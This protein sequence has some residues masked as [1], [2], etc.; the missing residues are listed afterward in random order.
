MATSVVTPAV[1]AVPAKSSSQ[2]LTDMSPEQK[3]HWQKTG[4]IVDTVPAKVETPKVS[5]EGAESSTAAKPVV[6]GA[7]KPETPAA[8]APA[9]SEPKGKPD[10]QSRI[11]Q[12]LADNKALQAKLDDL[13]KKPAAAAAPT[14]KKEELTKPQ[15]AD[16]D[17]K[18]G[19]A[20]YATDD[21]FET[22][23]EEYL[24]KKI[25][26]DIERDNAVAAKKAHDDEQQRLVT[27]KWNNSMKVGKEKH[28]DLDEVFET[29][30]KGAIQHPEIKGIK[31]G[32]ILD[33]WVVDSDLGI[34]IL[35][36]C[37]TTAGEVA[38]IQAMKPFEATRYLTKLEDK[39]SGTPSPKPPETPPAKRNISS[40]PAP[41]ADVSG[42]H[43]APTDDPVNK[44]LAESNFTAYQR[45]QNAKER[46]K[47]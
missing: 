34:E 37:A 18:T 9:T 21:E 6:A 25:R 11:L 39:L 22:A 10:A 7:E 12:L 45:E 15:R 44:A 2:I 16:V 47:K 26:A 1:P 24:T 31:P 8:S 3:L 33:G 17:E 32:G 27:E 42:K 30:D 46:R 29:D 20:K 4:E 19:I 43:T 36:H 5:T 41:A 35:Y 38:K 13:E 28:A 40:A 14:V 23:K